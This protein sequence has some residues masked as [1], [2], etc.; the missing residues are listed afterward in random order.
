MT[1]HPD[2]ERLTNASAGQSPE[3]TAKI[4]MAAA[5]LAALLAIAGS[6]FPPKYYA[7]ASLLLDYS[8]GLIKR[9]LVG[10]LL[11]P[12]FGPMVT[13]SELYLAA[14]LVTLAGAAALAFMV[15]DM[16]R[17]LP[18]QLV[19]VLLFSSFA[20]RSYVG[21]TGYMEGVL[22]VL[23]AVAMTLPASG[24]AG[25]LLR[26]ICI[27]VAVLAHEIALA[28]I[29][30][31]MVFEIWLVR[32]D[33]PFIG[34]A[35]VSAI[36]MLTALLAYG[37]VSLFGEV[38]P[39][40]VAAQDAQIAARLDPRYTFSSEPIMSRSLGDHLEHLVS[41]YWTDGKYHRW[42]VF[43]GLP[44]ALMSYWLGR[45]AAR[46]AP[47]R[48]TALIA[49]GVIVA[50]LTLNAIAYDVVRFGTMSVLSGFL[51]L[52][53]LH[54]AGHGEG[55]RGDAML[56]WPVFTVLLVLNLAITTGSINVTSHYLHQMPRVMTDH[57]LWQP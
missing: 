39:A 18:G 36:P 2:T 47:D 14:A 35:A 55:R 30:P 48:L 53:V 24:T 44:L 38:G 49:I 15:W 37:F 50:P 17:S 16:R 20:F 40:V 41:S 23:A 56:D 8:G 29:A 33:S 3:R 57:G 26:A 9:G 28:W 7:I 46:I 54:R 19:I 42:L 10:E 6:M 45:T 43:D 13:L 21:T 51:V 34:R 4:L 27:V 22:L 31:L 25:V 1:T 32:R 5:G 11:K 12:V 52:A